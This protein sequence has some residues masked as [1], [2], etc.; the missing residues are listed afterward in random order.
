MDTVLPRVSSAVGRPVRVCAKRICT[1][2]I[3][4]MYTHC[5]SRLVIGRAI[6]TH[7]AAKMHCGR[8]AARGRRR[9]ELGRAK[10]TPLGLASPPRTVRRGLVVAGRTVR[11]AAAERNGEL[12]YLA[13]DRGEA[14]KRPNETSP[15]RGCLRAQELCPP[16][17]S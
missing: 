16:H 4:R 14:R 3:E 1:R 9:T 11:A 12:S 5:V 15:D 6:T 17:V 10:R 7:P 8:I 2:S 13:R